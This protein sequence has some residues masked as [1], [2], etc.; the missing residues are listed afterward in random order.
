MFTIENQI[1]GKVFRTD[2][3]SAILEDALIQSKTHQR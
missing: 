2:G 1:T 3:D